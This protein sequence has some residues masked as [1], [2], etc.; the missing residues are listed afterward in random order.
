M[1]ILKMIRGKKNDSIT[2]WILENEHETNRTRVHKEEAK[3]KRDQFF[4]EGRRCP[5]CQKSFQN[6]KLVYVCP[7]CL[8]GLE[9]N[10]KAECRY[11][12]GY[13]NRKDKTE[14]MPKECVPCEKVMECML[15]QEHSHA[16]VA[17][18]RKWY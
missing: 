4:Q 1:G 12:F 2:L 18:I 3:K 7:H 6:P 15:G 9:E 5:K 11:G 8:T 10:W 17:E 13:L 14:S 16:A